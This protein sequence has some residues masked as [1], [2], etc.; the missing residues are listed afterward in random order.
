M[1]NRKFEVFIKGKR[2]VLPFRC[3]MAKPYNGSAKKSKHPLD[4][5]FL[6]NF[7]Y[8]DL[9]KEVLTLKA[10]IK[11]EEEVGFDELKD[12]NSGIKYQFIDVKK[13]GFEMLKDAQIEIIKENC[14]I[15]YNPCLEIKDML[16]EDEYKKF[17]LNNFDVLHKFVV[18]YDLSLMKFVI[19]N[20]DEFLKEYV[21][22]HKFEKSD[23]LY[24]VKREPKYLFLV[25]ENF[26]HVLYVEDGKLKAT[27]CKP[28]I[29]LNDDE[30]FSILSYENRFR[31]FNF[32]RE[33]L[34]ECFSELKFDNISIPELKK[35]HYIATIRNNYGYKISD[36]ISC[37][38]DET[39]KNVIIKLLPSELKKVV[40]DNL[41]SDF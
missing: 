22:I 34:P 29:V 7:F 32:E 8:Y 15:I 26:E 12:V 11:G 40:M 5:L 21:V 39:D 24:C 28:F 6:G 2:Y 27:D 1:E 17:H 41:L 36:E 16:S 18:Y 33:V 4:C 19:S 13:R 35:Y 3:E 14:P 38:N 30:D 10:L 20:R 31:R 23:A 25:S 9:G 37:F